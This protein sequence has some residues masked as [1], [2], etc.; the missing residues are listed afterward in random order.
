VESGHV[1]SLMPQALPIKSLG[2]RLRE[3]GLGGRLS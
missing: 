3:E 1:S 2:V